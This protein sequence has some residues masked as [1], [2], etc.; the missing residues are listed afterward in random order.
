ATPTP[1][2][3]VIG[4]EAPAGRQAGV[5]VADVQE[6]VAKLHNEAKVI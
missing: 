2:V 5:R 1:L 3:R 4:F 6:L